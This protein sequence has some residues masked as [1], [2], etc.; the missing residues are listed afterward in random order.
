MKPTSRHIISEYIKHLIRGSFM[1]T[2]IYFILYPFY[3]LIY[4]K[5]SSYSFMKDSYIFTLGVSSTHIIFYW[6]VNSFFLCCDIFKLFQK[7]KISPTKSIT[8]QK[9]LLFKTIRLA[10][11]NLFIFEP[12]GLCYGLWP[13]LQLFGCKMRL[14]T[15]PTFSYVFSVVL[16]S[17]LCMEW[18][19][20]FVH[21]LLHHPKLY[22]IHKQHHEYGT[23]ISFAAEY[24]HPIE[25]IFLNII[26]TIFGVLICGA[27]P[28]IFY[29]YL[30]W[31]LYDGYETHSGYSFVDTHLYNIFGLTCSDQTLYHDF[32]HTKNIGNYAQRMQDWLFATDIGYDEWLNEWNK[33]LLKQQ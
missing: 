1:A 7:Y 16:F 33:K 18:L 20:Y 21:R 2:S 11:F 13:L 32:H 14:N 3:N 5:L 19:F 30:F 28:L 12:I 23:S 26:P 27:H 31:R 4:D 25:G 8:Q 29:V 22:F 9:D 10:L 17:Q 6:L 24:V 15:K